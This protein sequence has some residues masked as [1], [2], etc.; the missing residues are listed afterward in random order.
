[1]CR[2]LSNIQDI[3]P[4]CRYSNGSDEEP[5]TVITAYKKLETLCVRAC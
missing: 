3:Y 5:G 1:M 2:L 4:G